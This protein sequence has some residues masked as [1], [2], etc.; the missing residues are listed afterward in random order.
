MHLAPKCTALRIWRLELGFIATY[1]LSEDIRPQK[2][3]WIDT[4]KTKSMEGLQARL[5]YWSK[6]GTRNRK[7]GDNA[8]VHYKC[9][10][11][12]N[13]RN[14]HKAFIRRAA[15]A[16]WL[17]KN[18]NLYCNVMGDRTVQKNFVAQNVFIQIRLN[19][20]KYYKNWWRWNIEYC[21]DRAYSIGANSNHHP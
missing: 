20:A 5:L 7:A 19:L 13:I 21:F 6:N 15:Y 1:R 4:T 18:G 3:L 16:Y 2:A 17:H 9:D 11:H 12:K 10:F 8:Q 14:A